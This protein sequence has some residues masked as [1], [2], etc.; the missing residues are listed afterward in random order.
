VNK[1]RKSKDGFFR[2]NIPFSSTRRLKG[3]ASNGF[4]DIE[5]IVYL[6]IWM[7]MDGNLPWLCES[8]V[9]SV[10][11]AINKTLELRK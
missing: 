3:G 1:P 9:N 10:H 7:L 6:A 4:D 11:E 8:A 2:G 5:S